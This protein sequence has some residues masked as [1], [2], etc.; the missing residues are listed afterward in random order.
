MHVEILR[1]LTVHVAL[2][3]HVERDGRRA[4]LGKEVCDLLV[5]GQLLPAELV[6][7]GSEDGESGRGIGLV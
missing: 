5:R 2:G 6:G 7:R 4:E 3:E 1:I